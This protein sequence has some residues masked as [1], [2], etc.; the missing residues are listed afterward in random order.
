MSGRSQRRLDDLDV[1]A[2]QN[3]NSIESL[4]ADLQAANDL[5]E[6]LKERIEF[7]E[8]EST[9]DYAFEMRE[10]SDSLSDVVQYI[11]RRDAVPNLGRWAKT[12]EE[13]GGNIRAVDLL[14]HLD[15]NETVI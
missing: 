12:H 1:R 11:K 13:L 4:T 15:V 10:L 5:I 14:E 3:T 8:G 2:H 9:R 7:L 6:S